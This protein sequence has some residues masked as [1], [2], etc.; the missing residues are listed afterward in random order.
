MV[1]WTSSASNFTSFSSKK[2]TKK[3]PKKLGCSALSR[4]VTWSWLSPTGAEGEIQPSATRIIQSAFWQPCHLSVGASWLCSLKQAALWLLQLPGLV[5]LLL[6]LLK[7]SERC[8]LG[9]RVHRVCQYTTSQSAKPTIILKIK[10]NKKKPNMYFKYLLQDGKSYR[11][12]I[13]HVAVAEVS[14]AFQLKESKCNTVDSDIRVWLYKMYFHFV[15]LKTKYPLLC[16]LLRSFS[17]GL[18]IF[19]IE[20]F[21]LKN[22]SGK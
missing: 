8:T 13:Y 9:N 21:F 11:K 20:H 14:G 22:D 1:K 16:T 10:T 2:K 17:G 7:Q 6:L 12:L 3:K 5:P 18:Y 4:P 15:T 19:L